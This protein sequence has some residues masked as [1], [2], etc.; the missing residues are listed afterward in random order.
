[1]TQT[2]HT[3]ALINGE[4]GRVVRRFPPGAIVDLRV[5]R[6]ECPNGATAT[7]QTG[8]YRGW[9]LLVAFDSEGE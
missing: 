9:T 1:L 4:L 6:L 7:V 8:R 2:P 5:A 3:H